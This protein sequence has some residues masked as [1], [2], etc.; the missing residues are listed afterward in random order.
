MKLRPVSFEW[1]DRPD[2]GTKL[3]LVAQEVE[4]ILPEVVDIGDNKKKTL[5]LFYADLIP[6]LIKATQDQQE[7]I[8]QQREI[9]TAQKRSLEKQQQEI[10]A[11]KQQ[12]A[13]IAELLAELH[14]PSKIKKGI[15]DE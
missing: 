6:V 14:T 11:L 2:Q 7:I 1:K 8:D 5:G 3:G 13:Q 12:Q 4:E 9:L 10:D 15:S